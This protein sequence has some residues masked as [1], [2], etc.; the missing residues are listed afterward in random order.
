MKVLFIL[1]L[2][3]VYS[4]DLFSI[5]ITKEQLVIRESVVYETNSEKPFTGNYESFYKNGELRLR[6]AYKNGQLLE[7]NIY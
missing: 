7:R 5:G 1:F 6:E 4:A 2:A 3:A